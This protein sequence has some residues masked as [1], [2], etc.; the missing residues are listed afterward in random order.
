[1]TNNPKN[2]VIT[3]AASGIGAATKAAF[4]ALGHK[5]IGVD[6]KNSEV[7][8]DLSTIAGREQAIADIL[9]AAQNRVDGL[10]CCA[11]LGV[12]APSNEMIVNVNYYGAVDVIEGLL[13][14]MPSKSAITVIGSVASNQQIA[15]PDGLSQALLNGQA[16]AVTETLQA[17]AGPHIAYSA[18]KYA[19]TAYCR[20]Q[21]ARFGKAQVRIN[22]VAPGAVA[23]PLHQAS[24]DDPRFGEAVKNFVSPMGAHTTP[25]HIA[26]TVSFLQSEAAQFIHG[27]VLFID[28]GIDALMRPVQF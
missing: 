20:Q 2:I 6:L 17:I 15:S 3:G 8:A 24:L 26:Q 22:V 27:S 25:E 12:T 16:D 1:M 28:G 9:Q 21:V 18:S 11:G 7:N 23:T 13:P 19:L 10:I 14:H 5:V 4:L